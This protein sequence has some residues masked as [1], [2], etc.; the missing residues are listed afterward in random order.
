[1]AEDLSELRSTASNTKSIMSYSIAYFSVA[2]LFEALAV[3]YRTFASTWFSFPPF[4]FV[5]RYKLYLI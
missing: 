1:M 5:Q 2:V 3:K 4:L